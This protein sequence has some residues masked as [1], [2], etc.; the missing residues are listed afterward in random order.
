L[1]V[2]AFVMANVLGSCVRKRRRYADGQDPA[3]DESDRKASSEVNLR[4]AHQS[5]ESPATI[6]L[7]Q[8]MFL[9]RLRERWPACVH[10]TGLR[11]HAPT[12]IRPVLRAVEVTSLHSPE[13]GK[14]TDHDVLGYRK[15]GCRSRRRRIADMKD[16]GRLGEK[17][18]IGKA[19][20][21]SH[22]LGADPGRRCN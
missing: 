4:Q 2:P 13:N 8:R 18:V 11:C 16:T 5:R 6:T 15:G 3:R 20:V 9:P 22:C 19:A 14:C 12:P 17:E 21:A 7:V 1:C 10:F